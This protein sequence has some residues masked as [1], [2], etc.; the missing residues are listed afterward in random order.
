MTV[1]LGLIYDL[2]SIEYYPRDDRGNGTVTSMDIALSLDGVH[3]TDL[4]RQNWERSAETK[5]VDLKTASNSA[6]RYVRLI[7]RASVGN[8]FYCQRN[9][10]Q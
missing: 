3:W 5:V 8:F 7:P 1:D 9:P 2:D 4:E 10:H 6:A